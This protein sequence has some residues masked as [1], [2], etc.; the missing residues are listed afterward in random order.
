MRVIGSKRVL[1]LLMCSRRFEQGRRFEHR[2]ESNASSAATLVGDGSPEGEAALRHMGD[3]SL[4]GG[5]QP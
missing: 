4:G 3:L 5:R 1:L 2:H